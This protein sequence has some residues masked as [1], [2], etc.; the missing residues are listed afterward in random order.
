M[1]LKCAGNPAYSVIQRRLVFVVG[2]GSFFWPVVTIAGSSSEILRLR[3]GGK[4]SKRSTS[5]KQV[6]VVVD[7]MSCSVHDV[8]TYYPLLSKLIQMKMLSEVVIFSDLTISSGG[9]SIMDLDLKIPPTTQLNRIVITRPPTAAT[10]ST[11]MSNYY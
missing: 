2:K 9:D 7:T 10:A 11:G 3:G 1:A 8:S 5:S 6:F 4:G